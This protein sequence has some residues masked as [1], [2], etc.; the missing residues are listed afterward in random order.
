MPVPHNEEERLRALRRLEVLDTGADERFDRITR[1]VAELLDVPIALVSLVDED[2]QWFKSSVGIDDTETPREVA[3]CSHA[4]LNDAPLIVQN[5]LEDTRFRDNPLVQG[6]PNIRFY[7]GA[8][9]ILGDE[10]RLGTLCAIDTRARVLSPQERRILLELSRVVTDELTLHQRNRELHTLTVQLADEQ[11]HLREANENLQN[12]AYMTAHDLRTPLKSI[13]NLCDLAEESTEGERNEFFAIIRREADR[14]EKLVGKYHGFS[15]LR[16]A[17]PEWESVR[18]ADLVS[19]TSATLEE[20]TVVTNGDA[21]VAGDRVLLG[22]LLVNLLENANKHG[23]PGN[24]EVHITADSPLVSLRVRN[25]VRAQV[26]VDDS[27]FEPFQTASS[28][29]AGTGLGLALVAR[30]VELHGGHLSASCDAD[31]FE[32][33]AQLPASPP[34]PE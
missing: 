32:I 1:L 25:P 10:I 26:E 13:V 11:L 22:Q 18:L 33:Q 21:T 7:A 9:L 20:R 4:I 5:A 27:L 12:F 17:T 24:I 30:I 29:R 2:R 23:A 6:H 3:F 34:A 16:T 28:E 14:A 15:R 19:E 8:P 31:H